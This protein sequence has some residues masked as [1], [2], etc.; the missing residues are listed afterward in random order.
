MLMVAPKGRTKLLILF[1]TPK[2]SCVF[3]IV[4]GNVPALLA[5]LNAT[6]AAG[7]IPLKNLKGFM[8]ANILTEEEYTII[9]CNKQAIP[10]AKITFKSG[11]N[12][13]APYCPIIGA[14]SQ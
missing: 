11:S 14:T 5:V 12:T 1:D 9:A 7:V 2:F 13:D 8:L 10:T 3:F 4:T 6:T